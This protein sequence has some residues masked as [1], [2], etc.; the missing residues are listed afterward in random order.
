MTEQIRPTGPR[1]LPGQD[2]TPVARAAW[3]VVGVL[4]VVVV[5]LATLLARPLSG[6][7]AAPATGGAG[8]TVAATGH[9]TEA[10]VSVQGM[11]FTPSTL[12]VPVGDRLVVTFVNTGDQ[13]HDLV[14]ANGAALPALAPGAQATLDVGV[15]GADLDGWCSLPGHRQ[16][17]MVMGVHAVGAPAPSDG[18]GGTAGPA[19]AAGADG[20]A[21]MAGHGASSPGPTMAE[22]RAAAATAA[23]HPADLPPL[24]DARE[25]AYTFTVTEGVDRVTPGLTR[26]V[27]TYNG[28]S[29]GPVLHG[30]VGDTFRITLVNAGTMGHSIDFHAGELAPDGPMRTLE[31][32]E[33]LEYTFTAHRA[34]IWMYHCSTMPMSN[35]IANGMFGAV[36]IEPDGLEPVD[37]SYV[38]LQ[39]E[40][41]LGADGE[42]ADAAKVATGIPDVVAF[43]GRAFQYDEHPL[44]ARAGERVRLWVLDAGPNVPLAFHVVGTQFDTVWREGAYSVYRGTS[45]DGRTQGTTGAQLLPLLAAEGG[46]VE[47]VAPEPGHYSFVDHAMSLAEKGAHGVLEVRP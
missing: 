13:R 44:T 6:A 26:A 29:P 14:F 18:A 24:S 38:L 22:L 37:R 2:G 42:P 36:V 35:H 39:S 1:P 34:G 19:G 23:A 25:H 17:G 43:N 15:I 31:P 47:L 9:T 8:A 40:Q 12:E 11:A 10:T 46:F 33:S 28:T 3:A 4:V 16:M 45:T 30:R 5:G 21:G 41:Y 32:G 20:M 7:E 27:W